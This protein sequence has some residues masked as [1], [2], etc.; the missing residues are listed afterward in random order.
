MTAINRVGATRPESQDA[1]LWAGRAIKLALFVTT[2]VGLGLMLTRTGTM[3]L[4]GR[5]MLGGGA[6]LLGAIVCFEGVRALCGEV[7]TGRA[8]QTRIPQEVAEYADQ[9]LG[10]ALQSSVISLGCGEV[11]DQVSDKDRSQL[12][13]Q[14]AILNE[15][16]EQ[17]VAGVRTMKQEARLV[18]LSSPVQRFEQA[19]GVI[20]GLPSMPKGAFPPPA[21]VAHQRAEL[22]KAELERRV[23]VTVVL[24]PGPTNG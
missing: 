11:I 16:Y 24:E 22:A 7:R 13:A 8:S 15:C 10:L 2:G 3:N 4:A 17:F 5:I 18:D 23:S 20:G 14:R 9:I 6:G 12:V 19:V 1:R 21:E